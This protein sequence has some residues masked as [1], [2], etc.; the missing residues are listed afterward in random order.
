M[1][2][3]SQVQPLIAT[4]LVIVFAMM[5]LQ[6]RHRALRHD[7][8]SAVVPQQRLSQRLRKSHLR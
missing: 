4:E 7:W 2:S 1:G 3:L 8:L 6:N 5:A